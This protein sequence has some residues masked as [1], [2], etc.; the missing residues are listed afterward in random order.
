M[1]QFFKNVFAS[2]LGTIIAMGIMWVISLFVIIWVIKSVAG[3]VKDFNPTKKQ[4]SITDDAIL[5]ISLSH[6]VVEKS[7]ENPLQGIE[8]PVELF[9][10]K[11]GVVNIV[12]AIRNATNNENVKAILLDLG[13]VNA[14]LPQLAEIRSA[15]ELFKKTSQK[16]VYAYGEYMSEKSYYLA[17]VADKVYIT[18]EGIV[19]FNGFSTELIFF[20]GLFEKLG[21]EP[22]IFKVGKFKSAVEPFFRKDMSEANRLQVSRFLESMYGEVLSKISKNRGVSVVELRNIANELLV[23]NPMDAV[24]HKL[25]DGAKYYDEVIELLKTNIGVDVN[26]EMQLLSTS[27]LSNTSFDLAT[28]GDKVAVVIAEGEIVSGTSSDGKL[29]ST[30]FIK[31][32]NEAVKDED[33]KA[34]VIRINSP[35]GSALASDVMW[36]AIRVAREKKPVI[37]SMSSLA[38]SGGYYMAAACDEIIAHPHTI[39]G[40]IGV[41][42]ILVELDELLE[43]KIGIT[44]DRVKTGR[45]ADIGMPTRKFTEEESNII[46]QNVNRTYQTFI[47]KV[48]E[49]RG[50][51]V[52]AVDAVASGRV[53]TGKDAQTKGLVDELGGLNL[54]LSKAA[55]KASLG[56]GYEV[57]YFPKN[58]MLFNFSTSPLSI[59]LSEVTG[60]AIPELN[61]I[62]QAYHR[63]Q[64]SNGVQAR[65]AFDV[66]VK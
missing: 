12:S 26:Q 39:T 62:L 25:I 16:P 47:T 30:S 7:D 65:M 58:Q 20:K 10:Q 17:S 51:T 11:S 22:K 1:G 59:R 40:S 49:G 6:A 21:V 36:H 54:A 48:A 52:N 8:L 13:I 15:L 4:V 41:F 24:K 5:K 35:G 33:I 63:L 9:I 19:E 53:W 32:L 14:G 31:N 50:M 61:K 38:A 3:E 43:N 45:F 55:E 27:D 44:T 29:G 28:G 56:D 23:Q 57:E 18:P 2:T 66:E 42:G 46:Q 60:I 64:N 34:I 37:A